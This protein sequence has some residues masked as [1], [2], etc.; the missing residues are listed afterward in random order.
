MTI[1]LPPRIASS[2]A[3]RDAM[4][5]NWVREVGNEDADEIRLGY[6]ATDMELA[7]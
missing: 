1:F 4:V 6:L 3:G 2:T 5:L 7:S